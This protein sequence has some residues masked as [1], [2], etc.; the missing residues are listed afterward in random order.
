MW[1]ADDRVSL[2]I[3]A[4]NSPFQ[5]ALTIGS[6]RSAYTA[7]TQATMSI[8]Q[9]CR[10]WYASRGDTARLWLGRFAANVGL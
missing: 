7:H 6:G 9:A 10:L 2:L 3:Y 8:G 5:Q 4:E 1:L